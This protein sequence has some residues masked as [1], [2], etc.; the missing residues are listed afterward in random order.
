MKD[1]KITQT[2]PAKILIVD[3][4]EPIRKLI[5]KY[6]SNQNYI[7]DTANDGNIALEKLQDHKYDLVLTD[8]RMPN[9]GGRELLQEMSDKY[10]DIPKIVLT[11]YGTNDDIIVALKTGAYDFLTK[12]ISDFTILKHS[13]DRAI[14]RKRLNDDRNKHVEQLKQINEIISMLNSG[15]NTEEIFHTLNVTL[16]KIIP[17]NRLALTTLNRENNTVNTKLVT[18]DKKILLGEGDAFNLNESSLKQCEEN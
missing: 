18:S 8:L 3:D 17:F 10:P 9:M 4:E 15:K 6:L 1:I 12:P 11:G 7:L 14:D 5:T 13:I 16:K 2:N